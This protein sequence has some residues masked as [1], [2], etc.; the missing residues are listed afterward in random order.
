M[1]G[2]PEAP[3][4]NA[5]ARRG[6]LATRYYATAHPSLP[7]YLALLGGS[8][9]GITA[10][11]PS[12][13]PAAPTSP[14]SSRAQASPGA[15]TWTVS[16]A[17]LPGQAGRR[18]VKRHDPFM[19][20]PSIAADRAAAP[21][22]CPGAAPHGPAAA[23]AARLRLDQPGPLRRRPQLQH[24][25][26]RPGALEA[27]PPV[28]R[29]LGPH[30]VLRHLRRGQ[31]QRRLLRGSRR[32]PRG[33]GPARA[34]VSR[35]TRLTR[36]Y[37]H[38]SLLA[39]I[40]DRFG[41]PRLRGAR[42]ARAL[43]IGRSAFAPRADSLPRMGDPADYYR[44]I[45]GS[46]LG[47]ETPSVPVA[48]A[49]LERRAGRGDGRARRQLRLRRRRH[50]GHDRRQPRGIPAAADRAADAARRRRAAT[51]PPPCSAPRCRRRCCWRR[52]ACR[53]SS[54][55]TASWR[56]PARRRRSACR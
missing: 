48:V 13:A 47:G 25:H 44:E 24:R 26:R 37:T 43:P 10:T 38:Y 12:A 18:Y 21:A 42:H 7:N 36:R 23:L 3:F 27:R 51:S 19:Y 34:R 39:T 1:T 8:T 14:T 2:S 50:R 53:R 55:P 29:Q 5:L 35:G 56:P 4:L 11:A 49:E 40:E 41:L 15:P 33:D 32:R 46:G 28:E 22:S 31:E 16:H 30:G 17:L 9:F 52:S 54:T 20:F 45:Y 6:A